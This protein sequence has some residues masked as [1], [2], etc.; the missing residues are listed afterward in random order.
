VVGRQVTARAPK[1][2]ASEQ[3]PR[4]GEGEWPGWSWARNPELWIVLSVAAL[5]RL[6]ALGTTPIGYDQVLQVQFARQALA[7]GAIPLGGLPASIGLNGS[8]LGI[9]L[10]IPFAAAGP[11]PLPVAASIA[12]LNVAGVAACYVFTLRCFGRRT[13]LLATLLYATCG[14]AVDSSRFIWLPN[15]VPA[16]LAFWALTLEAGVRRR[17]A[18]WL[19]PNVALLLA[20]ILLHPAAVLLLPALIVALLLA[21]VRLRS[22]VWS[23][24]IAVLLLLPNLLWEVL[25]GGAD[26]RT[27]GQYVGGGHSSVNFEVLFRIYELFGGPQSALQPEHAGSGVKWMLDLIFATPTRSVFT[28]DAPYNVLALLY[29]PLAIAA[30]LLFGVGWLVLARRVARPLVRAWRA[31]GVTRVAGGGVVRRQV[32]RALAAWRTARDEPLWRMYVVLWVVVTVPPALTLRHNG[33]IQPHYLLCLYPF[34]FITA[35]IGGIWL[36]EAAGRVPIGR[37][38]WR[39]GARRVALGRLAVG[40]ALLV[41]VAGQAAQSVL[42]TASFAGGAYELGLHPMFYTL[43][44]LQ[45]A[46]DGLGQIIQAQSVRQTVLLTTLTTQSMLSYTLVGNRAGRRS[47]DENCLLLPGGSDSPALVVSSDPRRRAAQ[48]LLGLPNARMVGSVPLEG[49]VPL[50]VFRIEGE[51]PALPDERALQPVAFEDGFGYGLRLD[52]VARVAPDGLRLRWTV[53]G[54]TPS[55]ATAPGKRV[56]LT[57]Q[58]ADGEKI[59]GAWTECNPTAWHAG[60]TVFTWQGFASLPGGATLPDLMAAPSL[61]PIMVGVSDFTTSTDTHTLGGVQLISGWPV[62]NRYTALPAMVVPGSGA[63]VLVGAR[64]VTVT[65]DDLPPG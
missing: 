27:L 50:A 51:T 57:L 4:A 33:P 55:G 54:T 7:H 56:I 9:Y 21:P 34:C 62:P 16:V 63:A 37:V 31:A 32:T 5:L 29:V 36:V 46:D 53:P 25:S 26:L 28:P 43:D 47:V 13:A 18:G 60:D 17:R 49:S 20:A 38:S 65:A 30:M 12:L 61:D 22:I 11:S 64:G 2:D 45:S 23:V 39:V 42:T 3:A 35:A 10:T 8:P 6:W 58:R 52:A 40:G 48:L 19:A 44:A 1:V 14:A 59:A 24:V 15:Y 41:L